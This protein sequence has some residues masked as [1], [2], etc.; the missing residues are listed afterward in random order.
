MNRRQISTDEE[1]GQK[2]RFFVARFSLAR[3]SKNA[4]RSDPAGEAGGV[5]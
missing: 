2:P 1:A 3:F 5:F 4:R